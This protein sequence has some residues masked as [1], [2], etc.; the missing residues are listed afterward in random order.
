MKESSFKLAYGIEV[1]ISL[2]IRLS[3]ARVEQYSEPS[4]SECR[5]TDLD[6]L[7]EVCQQAQ[8]WMTVY[9]Q[10]VA[11]YYNAKVKPKIFRLET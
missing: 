6:L 3:S 7:Q 1:M 5:R 10:R 4:N 11:L 8:I 2:E 9:Q